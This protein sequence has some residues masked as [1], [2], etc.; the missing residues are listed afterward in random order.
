MSGRRYRIR[1]AD[2]RTIDAA[3]FLRERLAAYP[4]MVPHTSH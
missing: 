1:F 2:G 3:T 4:A